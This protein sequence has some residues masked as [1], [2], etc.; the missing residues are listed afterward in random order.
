MAC[1][2]WLLLII[3]V[4]ALVWYLSEVYRCAR[5]SPTGDALYDRYA[6]TVIQRQAW[7]LFSS[8]K[9]VPVYLPEDVLAKWE[10]EFG[11]DPRYWQLKYWCACYNTGA[12]R[13]QALINKNIERQ[14]VSELSA[15]LEQ[16]IEHGAADARSYLQLYILHTSSEPEGHTDEELAKYQGW[17]DSA[18]AADPDYAWPYYFNAMHNMGAVVKCDE[19]PELAREQL[20]LGNA[21]PE[22]SQPLCF[23][24]S[25]V[26]D[27]AADNG[28]PAGNA[29]VA[30]AIAEYS[31]LG[32]SPYSSSLTFIHIKEL[33]KHIIELNKAG[34]SMELLQNYLGMI[35]R[36]GESDGA[37]IADWLVIATLGDSLAK[38][39]SVD[40]LPMADASQRDALWEESKHLMR[41]YPLTLWVL[42]D[43]SYERLRRFWPFIRAWDFWNAI[44]GA[45]RNS[46]FGMPYNLSYSYSFEAEMVCNGNGEHG[47]R[48]R[49]D[50]ARIGHFDFAAMQFNEDAAAM[51]V[52]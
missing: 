45:D 4:L 1:G 5:F 46:D 8:R 3:A 42:N 34:E 52:P 30:G 50:L 16:G 31:A 29:V 28:K 32:F 9:Q 18:I 23:P 37:N 43:Q 20:A 41:V 17:L 44:S 12:R 35:C 24:A 48:I 40:L 2:G 39:I 15:I 27:Y 19:N 36:Y 51:A 33:C 6:R 10:P 22:F 14:L 49:D 13:Q 38:H 25:F 21:A 11:S 47:Q 7:R 26:F